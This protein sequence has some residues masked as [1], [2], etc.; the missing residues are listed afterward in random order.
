MGNVLDTRITGHILSNGIVDGVPIATFAQARALNCISPI[1]IRQRPKSQA[2]SSFVTSVRLIITA[3]ASAHFYDLFSFTTNSN[4]C[5]GVGF[6][7][8]A[9]IKELR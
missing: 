7:L 4:S 1:A 5:N 8:G 6:I 2:I 3:F 9:Y